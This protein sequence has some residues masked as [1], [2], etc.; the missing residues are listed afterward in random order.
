MQ[1]LPGGV[2]GSKNVIVQSHDIGNTVWISKVLKSHFVI[3][4]NKTVDS[5]DDYLNS[6]HPFLFA[7][8]QLVRVCARKYRNRCRNK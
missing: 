7:S 5:V 4:N 2:S 6:E 8:E 3:S 1:S